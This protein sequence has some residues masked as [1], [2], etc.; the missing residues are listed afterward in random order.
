[1]NWT[2]AIRTREVE[3]LRLT[4]LPSGSDDA[5]DESRVRNPRRRVVRWLAATLWL[6]RVL[7]IG[8]GSARPLAGSGGE[9]NVGDDGRAVDR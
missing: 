2:K 1:M 6:V 3:R 8:G 7:G 5:S 4:L 9:P